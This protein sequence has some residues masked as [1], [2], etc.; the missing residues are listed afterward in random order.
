M[1]VSTSDNSLPDTSD[2]STQNILTYATNPSYQNFK[3]STLIQ[4]Y[5]LTTGI[6]GTF[7]NFY[8]IFLFIKFSKLRV[9]QCNWLIVIQSLTEILIE[10]G[11]FMRAVT[12]LAAVAGDIYDFNLVYCTLT[13]GLC[14][15]GYRIGQTVA[16]LIAL[17]RLMAIWKPMIYAKKQGHVS[18]RDISLNFLL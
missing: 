3:Y 4:I 5:Y 6:L 7:L 14:A 15:F 12:F 2:N 17:D 8:L 10:F 13:G 11:T 9:N 1:N 16:L 18:W